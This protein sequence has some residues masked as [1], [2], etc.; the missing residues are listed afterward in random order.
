VSE[1]L[2]GPIVTAV[3][4][5]GGAVVVRTAGELDLYNADELREALGEVAARKPERLV[6]DLAGISFIDSRRGARWRSPGS[7]AT[8]PC[9]R[10]SRRRWR[11]R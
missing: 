8:C 6:L 10:R 11:H 3:E 7:T 9:T 2:R 5:H 4:E 1:E